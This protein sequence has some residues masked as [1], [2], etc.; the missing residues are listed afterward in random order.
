[1]RKNQAI[2]FLPANSGIYD[3]QN[4]RKRRDR[5]LIIDT[6]HVSN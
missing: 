4:A 6:A 5:P 3:P 1:M 2:F